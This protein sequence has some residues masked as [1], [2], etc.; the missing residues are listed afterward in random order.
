MTTH[1][2]IACSKSKS[3]EPEEILIWS[4]D[5]D[6]NSWNKNWQVQKSICLPEQLYTGRSFKQ[7]YKIIQEYGDCE[8][9]I[10]SAGGG[11]ISLNDAIPSYESTFGKN[12][13]PKINQWHRLPHG[14][15]E[16]LEIKSED[17]VVTFAPPKYHR[18]LLNDP[19]IHSIAEKLVVA[20]TS[21][22]APISSTV[23]NIHPRSKE[24][25]SVGSSDLNTEFLRIYLSQGLDGFE[26][27][28]REGEKLPP[29]LVRT[30]I[31][32][33]DLRSLVEELKNIKSLSKL[34]R[35]LRD[36]LQIKASFERISAAR[37]N[38]L[39]E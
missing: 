13:G 9:H 6:I 1:V 16:K 12:I 23:I 27:I 3:L 33:E 24:V 38:L 29:K 5:S 36:E 25:L 39:N 32:D 11:L 31:T 30:P 22:L 28:G 4:K 7:Q 37:K 35:H 18:A 17:L 19:N 26:I 20:S 15:T 10:I 2:L 8:L 34:V 21:P 14:G